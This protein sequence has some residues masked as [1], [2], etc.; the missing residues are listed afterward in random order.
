MST[1]VLPKLRYEYAALEPHIS[2]RILELHHDAHHAAYVKNANAV[3]ERIEK[4]RQQ[5]D[6]ADIGALEKTLA[7]NL[8]GHLLHSIFWENLT[9]KG[10][11]TPQGDLAKAIDRDFGSFDKFKAQLTQAANTC[12]GSGWGALVLDTAGR[13]L[14]VVQIHDHQSTTVQGAAPLMVLDAWEHAYYLQYEN[15]K[16]EFFNAIWNLWNWRDIE[17]RFEAAKKLDLMLPGVSSS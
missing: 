1:Y 13:R 14:L 2:R 5:N 4:A 9:P 8:S 12:M 7:F 15:R 11:G 17:G 3:L 10:G 6:L 16:A